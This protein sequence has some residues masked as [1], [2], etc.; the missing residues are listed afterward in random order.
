MR[1]SEVKRET[2]ETKI[3]IKINLDGS[4]ESII[5]TPIN[6]F[7]HM[8]KCLATH[9]LFDINIKAEG[10]LKHHIIE[11]VAITLGQSIREASLEI[12]NINRFGYAIV[13][14][15]ESLAIASVDYSGRPFS[16]INLETGWYK[17]EDTATE[18]LIHFLETLA[19]SMKATIHMKVEY[20]FNDHH[21]IEAAFKALAQALRKALSQDPQ[22][23]GIPSSKG[24]I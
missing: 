19:I 18:D 3:Y 10:D 15:D 17:I 1:I 4:G 12:K 11:D 9:S 5:D 23:A 8:L 7:N 14:M 13:P 2:K 6:F 20:G 16:K 21:K 22:R 24:V